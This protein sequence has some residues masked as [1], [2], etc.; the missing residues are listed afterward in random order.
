ML[1]VLL[2]FIDAL[3]PFELT[4]LNAYLALV[5]ALMAIALGAVIYF[6]ASLF[7]PARSRDAERRPR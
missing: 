6:V 7:D 1:N 5:T 3:L 4:L 2:D